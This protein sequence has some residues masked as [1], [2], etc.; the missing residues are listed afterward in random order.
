MRIYCDRPNSSF[1]PNCF[2]A[3]V[4]PFMAELEAAGYCASALH[5]KRS[6]LRQFLSWRRRRKR[7][8]RE[9]DES[10]VDLFLRRVCV[11]GPKQRQPWRH[12][13]V[14]VFAAPTPPGGD[15]QLRSIA[16]E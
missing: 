13:F 4:T 9:P 2:E 8:E 6:A 7:S 3:Q 5:T 10:E 15:R 11:F 16:F 12:G 14:G 1:I